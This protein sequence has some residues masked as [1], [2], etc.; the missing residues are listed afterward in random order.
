MKEVV[1]SFL[2]VLLAISVGRA[3]EDAATKQATKQPPAARENEVSEDVADASP[4]E[5]ELGWVIGT[6]VDQ[7]EASTITTTCSWTKNHKF[8]TRSF[9]ISVEGEVTLEGTQ[10]IGWDPANKQIRS[11]TF[12]SEGGFGTGIWTRKGNRIVVEKKFTL[13]TGERASA[14]NIITYVDQD[15]V[16]WQSIDREI[17]GELQP[18]IPEVTIV[19]QKP[20]P[21]EEPATKK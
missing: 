2:F 17:G 15:T 16:R 4:L 19:R 3:E 6:W 7:G 10:V 5:Q 8:L 12:D 11:W 20:E 21:T 13:A 18:N 14:L 9:A 1:S